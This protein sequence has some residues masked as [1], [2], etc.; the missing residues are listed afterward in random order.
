MSDRWSMTL[1][2]LR[3]AYSEVIQLY[4]SA[5]RG[6]EHMLDHKL[7][8]ARMAQTAIDS[9]LKLINITELQAELEQTQRLIGQW[10]STL[11]G[12]FEDEGDR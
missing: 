8:A 5:M 10:R 12:P 1:T 6:D 7:Q 3:V 9:Y 4:L 11:P 2:D